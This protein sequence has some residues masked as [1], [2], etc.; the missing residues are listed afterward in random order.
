M[1]YN[2]FFPIAGVLIVLAVLVACTGPQLPASQTG[3]EVKLRVVAT[4]SI[5]SDVVGQVGGVVES[6]GTVQEGVEEGGQLPV[7]GHPPVH[8]TL[9][10]HGPGQLRHWLE[11]GHLLLPLG[12]LLD[13]PGEG[14]YH[15][16]T[17]SSEVLRG[18]TRR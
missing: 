8:E 4:T 1:R 18:P 7:P 2:F 17:L 16:S 6:G 12:A 9:Q 14:L 11:P 13:K 5:V 10:I 3:G 15:E